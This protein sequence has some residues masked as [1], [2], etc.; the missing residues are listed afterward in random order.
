[1]EDKLIK[2]F[3]D[4]QGNAYKGSYKASW[5]D[6][7][8]ID[9]EIEVIGQYIAKGNNVLDI[10]CASGYSTIKQLENKSI[11][12][13]GIDYSDSM[14]QGAEEIKQTLGLGE[15]IE[16]QIGN[17]LNIPFKDNLFDVV[18]T[19]RTIINLP[20]WEKQSNAIDECLRVTKRGGR[21]IF[22]EAFLEPML[23]LNSVRQLCGLEPLKEPVHNLYIKKVKFENYLNSKEL[24]YTSIDF[25]SVYYLGSR[26]LRELVLKKDASRSYT[27]PINK[28]F[29]ELEK[30]YSG[31][32][33][34]IQ[35][36]YI[37]EK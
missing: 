16:F 30:E 13:T 7:Y 9:L 18:Y 10:G 17:I 11:K 26:L 1:M 37:V 19:T 35:R 24:K 14:I 20:N 15:Q 28:I 3:W 6:I 32:G 33:F 34:G 2:K 27:N 5:E 4:K 8:V 22:S 31:G 12:I 23:L 21:V 25:S 29:Y 36:I